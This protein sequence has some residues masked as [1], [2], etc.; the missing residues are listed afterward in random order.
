MMTFKK[1]FSSIPVGTYL[2]GAQSKRAGLGLLM[3]TYGKFYAHL[4]FG[5]YLATFGKRTNK[6]DQISFLTPPPY[7]NIL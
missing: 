2:L 3:P 4:L 7:W 6:S 1:K 5:S